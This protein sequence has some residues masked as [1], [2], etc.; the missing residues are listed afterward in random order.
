ME[1]IIL[2]QQQ[3]NEVVT[4]DTPL[5][6][7]S[8]V[9][10]GGPNLTLPRPLTEPQAAKNLSPTPSS[11]ITTNNPDGVFRA[12]L[13]HIGWI[14]LFLTLS[15]VSCMQ[16]RQKCA[17][18]RK[19]KQA[20]GSKTPHCGGDDESDEESDQTLLE[21]PNGVDFASGLEGYSLREGSL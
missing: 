15:M 14:L 16:Q 8:V 13:G 4:E 11:S 3:I 6:R 20:A 9:D 7:G 12:N 17:A 2:N 21:A 18:R 10:D 5:L 19:K 1:Q